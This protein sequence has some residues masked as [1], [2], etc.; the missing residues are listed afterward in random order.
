ML[1]RNQY[2]SG[3]RRA[4]DNFRLPSAPHVLCFRPKYAWSTS[5]T[6]INR[7]I[8][9][10]TTN[11]ILYHI[12]WNFGKVKEDGQASSSDPP[13]FT[14]RVVL[15][16]ESEMD[17]CLESVIYWLLCDVISV[18]LSILSC[19]IRLWQVGYITLENN[20]NSCALWL[21]CSI[22]SKSISGVKYVEVTLSTIV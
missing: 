15:C 8:E 21:W 18:C 4:E 22:V 3:T 14:C 2:V 6:R 5:A 20:L 11:H 12:G 19:F 1:K 16:Y 9:Y 13:L 10:A 17:V 7:L